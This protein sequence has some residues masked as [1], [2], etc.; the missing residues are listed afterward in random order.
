MNLISTT[1]FRRA[2]TMAAAV[3]W[4]RAAILAATLLGITAAPTRAD[5]NPAD[6]ISAQCYPDLQTATAAALAANQ[7][8]WL[9]AGTYEVTH[10]LFI[11]YT[12][13]ARVGFTIISDGAI[14]DGRAM[15]QPVVQIEC[16]SDC[17]YFHLVGTLTVWADVS[18]AAFQ[19]GKLD[20]SDPHNSA[21]IDHLIVNNSDPWGTAVRF[22]YVLNADVSVYAVGGYVGLWLRQ[23]Q[24]SKI[25]GAMTGE[26]GFGILIDDGYTFA[27]TIQA[28]DVE[29]SPYCMAIWSPY[30]NRNTF[31]SPYFNC[32]TPIVATA[33]NSNMLL[34]AS[35]GAA[36]PPAPGSQTGILTLP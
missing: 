30:A 6:R 8:L 11:D 28:I 10:T 29:S 4:V 2:T 35:Y 21:K 19:I 5:C 3:A 26:G 18:D 34:N 9:P 27:N 13:Q 31:V 12:P 32:P 15:H 16:A 17:F 24:F 25:N 1:Y 23:V 36:Q 20:F 14:I 33:G 7:P 22:N